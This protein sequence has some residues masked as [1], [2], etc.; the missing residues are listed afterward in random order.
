MPL[1]IYPALIP[2]LEKYADVAARAQPLKITL[3][4]RS[5]SL[6]GGYDAVHLDNVLAWAV[7]HE[8]TQGTGLPPSSDLYALPVPLS[9]LWKSADGLPLWAASCFVPAAGA[10]EGAA[11]TWE[12]TEYLHK[13]AISGRWSRG[14]A[15]TGRLSIDT[16]RGRDME[17]R[18]PV[19][20]KGGDTWE[21]WAWGD[22]AETL[23]LLTRI[24]FVG[25]RRG[26]GG[27]EVECWQVE[28]APEMTAW[29]DAA[30]QA[31]KLLRPMPLGAVAPLGLTIAPPLSLLGWTPPYWR[32]AAQCAGW[33]AG[34][35][36]KIA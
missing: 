33:A 27:G 12:D 14:D 31:G 13:R 4:L 15:R 24:A 3:R 36:V 6:I 2:A 9:C 10:Q 28:A 18:I 1:T 25:K 32:P 8:A 16:A 20:Q 21:A 34:T 19:P 22:G 26:A 5:G 30:V 11:E 29:R 7:M 17:R 23:R 35:E